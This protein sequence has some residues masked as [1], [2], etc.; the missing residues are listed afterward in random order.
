MRKYLRYSFGLG[1]TAF[2]YDEYYER[3]IYETY[4]F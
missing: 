4:V 1:L 2:G 3:Y